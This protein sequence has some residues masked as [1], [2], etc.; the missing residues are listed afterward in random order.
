M[1]SIP[2]RRNDASHAR[3]MR[4]GAR[5]APPG[6]DTP[7]RTF[8]ATSTSS[9]WSASHGAS[10]RSEVPSPYVS[11]VSTTLPPAARYASRIRCASS[12]GIWSP[13]SIAPRHRRLTRSGPRSTRSMERTIGCFAMTALSELDLPVLDYT[14]PTLRGPGFHPRMAQLAEQGWLAATPLGAI[15]LD[16]EAAEL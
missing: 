13:M 9:R 1:T 10:V 2:R 6:S 7:K 12:G 4:S 11:A 8:V 14:D 3:A 15:V 5:P 16:R